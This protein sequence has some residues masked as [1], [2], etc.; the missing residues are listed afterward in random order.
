VSIAVAG[1]AAAYSP[2]GYPVDL[3]GDTVND[4]NG[5]GVA[6]IVTANAGDD[7]VS[8]LLGNGGGTF[9]AH[10]DYAVGKKPVAVALGDF[11]NDQRPD[12]VTANQ[13]GNSISVLINQGL[14]AFRPRMDIPIPVLLM[15][16]DDKK[17]AM[18]SSPSGVAVA[19]FNG[20]GNLDLVTANS[21]QASVSVLLGNGDGSFGVPQTISTLTYASN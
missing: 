4:L 8:V 20:D 21:G 11:N 9:Q 3:N 6:D 17:D 15:P 16:S 7:T 1:A 5:D 2:S 13:S 12:I 19:D 10:Q 18:V 14:G